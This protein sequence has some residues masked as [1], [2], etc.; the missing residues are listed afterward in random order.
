MEFPLC[1]RSRQHGLLF[2]QVGDETIIFDEERQE[3]HSLNRMASI[4]WRHID[5]THTIPQLAAILGRELGIEANDSIVEHALDKL[6]SVHL[7]EGDSEESSRSLSRRAVMRRVAAAGVAA[8]GLPAVLTIMAPTSAMAA[9]GD[10]TPP[11]DS[12]LDG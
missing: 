10:T 5:G 7:L 4:I 1:P 8:V 3:V 9:S 12:G 2:D 6:A 11:P